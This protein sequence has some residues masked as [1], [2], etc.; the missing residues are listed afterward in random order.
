MDEVVVVVVTG[1]VVADAP[2]VNV[3]LLLCSV[4]DFPNE[5]VEAD[6]VAMLDP[7]PNWKTPLVSV[8]GFAG[9]VGGFGPPNAKVLEGAAGA[10]EPDEAP[11]EKAAPED[12]VDEADGF[13]NENVDVAAVVV[14]V[15][16]DFAPPKGKTLVEGEVTEVVTDFPN[17]N[18][19]AD[20]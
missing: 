1:A 3:E 16:V 2:N 18:A 11:N 6:G 19:D 13:P 9:S 10:A 8:A 14:V 15:F 17:E 12:D 4:V 5:K 7:E 20:V